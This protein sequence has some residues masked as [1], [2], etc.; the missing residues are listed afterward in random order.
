M[1]VSTTSAIIMR[2]PKHLI[3][4]PRNTRTHSKKQVSQLCG[5]INEFGFTNPPIVDDES[6]VIAGHGRLL[7]AIEL[8]LPLVPTIVVSGL[9]HNQKRAL[10]IADNKLALNSGWDLELLAEELA[11]LSSP[12]LEFDVSITG[13]ETAEI[14]LIIGEPEPKK[15]PDPADQVEAIDRTTPAVSRLGDLWSL[16]LH[17]LFCGSSEEDASYKAVMQD[18]VAQQV[19]TDPPYNVPIDGH[20]VGLG[21]VRHAEFARASGEMSDQEFFDFLV[22]TFVVI[23]SYTAPG[24]IVMVFMDWRHLSEAQRAGLVAF[25]E[26]KNICVWVKTNGGMGS[27]YRSQHEMVL[28]FKKAGDKHINN[29]ELGKHGRY[30]TN[31][32][33]Y[34]GVNTFGRN[35]KAD[36]ETHPTVKPI[37]MI[38][39]AIKDCS[40][41]GGII[42][43]AFGGSGT[44]LLAAERTGRRARLIEIDP[45]YVDATIRRF[46]ALTKVEAR[47][48]DTG[49]TFAE[50]EARRAADRRSG[51]AE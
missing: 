33:T 49:E 35:R 30:R 3:P 48:A 6:N 4:S 43:D 45:Y 26:L 14:D 39:D 1:A 8:G 18:E 24:A 10:A 37:A 28:I 21:A 5:A 29:I 15:R 47:L 44:T 22:T 27:F 16:G 50:V 7:A 20:V 11:D 2:N 23:A 19:V 17:G 38:M 41:R 34:A 13:F 12:D 9:T 25:A 51:A 36:L 42:L 32:W 31:V 40:A 46:E